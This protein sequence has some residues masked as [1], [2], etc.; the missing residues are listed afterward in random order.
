MTYAWSH[1][2]DLALDVLGRI[3]AQRERI[4]SHRLGR[5]L[6]FRS[7]A[8]IHTTVNLPNGDGD[9]IKV[10]D[11]NPNRRGLR[12]GVTG[13]G[14]DALLGLGVKPRANINPPLFIGQ[15]GLRLAGNQIVGRYWDGKISGV[16]WTGE[17][18]AITAVVAVLGQVSALSIT[19]F[20]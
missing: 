18:Y 14:Q 12:I 10:L 7:Q 17:I 4:A 13:L 16:L 5:M 1:D 8:A 9:P 15:T 3:T 2:A 19:E 6:A 11:A 20:T